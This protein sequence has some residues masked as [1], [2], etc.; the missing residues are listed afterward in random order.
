MPN[1]DFVYQFVERDPDGPDLT[2]LALHGTGGS[3]HDLAGLA[4]RLVPGA[5]ILSPRGKVLE[6]GMARFFK[7]LSPGVFD[8]EDLR[9]RTH[10]LADFVDSAAERYALG[11]VVAL[12]FSNGANIAS[13]VLLLR[14]ETL[15]G[16][17]LLRPMLPLEPQE[18]PDLSGKPVF[19]ASGETD[20][21][22]TKEEARRLEK[23]LQAA[24]ALVTH[25]WDTGGHGLSGGD[26]EA[27]QEWFGG[28]F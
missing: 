13:S 5:A 4:Q 22:V 24:G 25:Y 11:R 27:A 14:P 20:P 10:E 19:L 6:N 12:G 28:V 8:L 21:Y 18:L 17:A 7:R 2:L 1:P 15:S 3:E 26:V 9:Q 23:T 16:A